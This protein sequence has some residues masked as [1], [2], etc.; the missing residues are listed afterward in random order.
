MRTEAP[1][2]RLGS[3]TPRRAADRHQAAF[4]RA[5]T[6]MAFIDLT[7]R[8]LAVNEALCKLLGRRREDLVGRKPVDLIAPAYGVDIEAQISAA[9]QGA[10]S[11]LGGEFLVAKPDGSVARA[12]AAVVLVRDPDGGPACFYV[13]I[14]DVTRLWEAEAA[15]ATTKGARAQ[16]LDGAVL[17]LHRA[18]EIRDPYT[19][20]HQ[21]RVADHARSIAVRLGL[22]DGESDGIAVAARIH[23]I[24]KIAIPSEIL[25]RPGALTAAE[26]GVVMS[27]SQGGHDIVAGIDFPWPVARM[28][29]EHH[30]RADGTGY[31]NGRRV[32]EL[33]LGSCIIAVADAVDAMSSHRPYRPA[34]G[35]DAALGTL[36]AGQGT[37]FHPDVVEAALAHYTSMG[38]GDGTGLQLADLTIDTRRRVA[39]V[40]G[41]TLR[42]TRLEFDL[43]AALAED[44]G[45]AFTRDE[46]LEAVWHSSSDWQTPATVTEHIRR[47]R[48]KLAETAGRTPAIATVR[49]FGYALDPDPRR[50]EVSRTRLRRAS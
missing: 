20:G 3:E 21:T 38:A 29:L 15:L 17:A 31:P 27:H 24:G 4:D 45:R 50:C 32:E 49:G 42:L 13:Q 48:A 6:P 1:Q 8:Y 11:D 10:D 39:H 33:L 35:V 30:E 44:P 23:D 36:V 9:V 47:L 22:D 19:A 12:N 5:L 7:G 16:A 43:L 46:L 34:L 26:M 28:I 37:A 14:Q 25:N 18:L 41:Q 2:P 40:R